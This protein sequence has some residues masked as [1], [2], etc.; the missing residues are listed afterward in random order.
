MKSVQGQFTL[1][2]GEICDVYPRVELARKAGRLRQLIRTHRS[3]QR[4]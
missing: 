1:L 2:F 3:Q 4:P